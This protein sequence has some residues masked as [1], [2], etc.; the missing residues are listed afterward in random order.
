MLKAVIRREFHTMGGCQTEHHEIIIDCPEIEKL[1]TSEDLGPECGVYNGFFES[2]TRYTPP[3][4]ANATVISTPIPKHRPKLVDI[5]FSGYGLSTDGSGTKSPFIAN[6]KHD[7]VVPK[8]GILEFE[9]RSD[10]GGLLP[11]LFNLFAQEQQKCF[12]EDK[13]FKNL[14]VTVDN[15]IYEKC[16][17]VGIRHEFFDVRDVG[18]IILEVKVD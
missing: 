8:D 5:S 17:I 12:L 13:D 2:L 18:T 16:H 9:L 6:L 7:L 10:V 4:P 14:T 1:L 3:K 15:V 11:Q